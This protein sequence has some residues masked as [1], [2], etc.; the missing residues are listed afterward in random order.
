MHA[1]LV[2]L[3][4]IHT[5]GNH[6]GDV[7]L[8]HGGV[9]ENAGHFGQ[10]NE[11]R[12]TLG[13]SLESVDDDLELV[14]LLH[15]AAE[16]H[17]DNRHGDG[18]HHTHDTAAFEQS[19]HGVTRFR[20][21]GGFEH[22]ERFVGEVV[23]V[24]TIIEDGTKRAGLRLEDETQNGTDNNTEGDA[25][26]RGNLQGNCHDNDDRRQE[27]HRVDVEDTA[28][29][30][31]QRVG[32]LNHAGHICVAAV[33]L[34]STEDAKEYQGNAIS[35]RSGQDHGLDVGDHVRTCHGGSKVRRIGQ[36][37][38]LIA[39]VGAGE[40]RTGGHAGAHAETEADTHQGNAHRTHR[41]PGGAGGE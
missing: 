31:V 6:D 29:R 24:L 11:S 20:R 37:A 18:G 33:I 27:Q 12:R 26:D 13:K 22:G 5:A 36:R 25:G 4:G 35:N 38:H 23:A 15:D 7:L 30:S 19:R 21:Q 16:H 17:G 2:I 8:G 3:L 34:H 10:A 40:N 39:E 32:E 28:L 14:S 1:H 9:G 41:A